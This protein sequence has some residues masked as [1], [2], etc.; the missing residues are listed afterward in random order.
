[1]SGHG[2]DNGAASD[3]A[4]NLDDHFDDTDDIAM[5][6]N[7]NNWRE[8]FYFNSIIIHKIIKYLIF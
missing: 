8:I 1:M 6:M 3:F 7:T 5:D 2:G 4:D